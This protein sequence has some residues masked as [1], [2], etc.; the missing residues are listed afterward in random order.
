MRQELNILRVA[1]I[2]NRA[3]H[4]SSYF[5]TRLRELKLAYLQRQV[6]NMDVGR[7]LHRLPT[8]TLHTFR[9]VGSKSVACHA[10]FDSFALTTLLLVSRELKRRA[11]QEGTAL[12]RA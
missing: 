10:G 4:Q 12:R 3:R 7:M 9:T 8:D 5:P 11:G 6:E 2:P 1:W